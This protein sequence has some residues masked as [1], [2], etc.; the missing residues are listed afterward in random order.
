MK[1][2]I[3][4]QCV[5]RDEHGEDYPCPDRGVEISL[6]EDFH[7]YYDGPLKL[8]GSKA[9]FRFQESHLYVDVEYDVDGNPNAEE[10]AELVSYTQGQWSD[11]IGE[12]YEQFP[13]YVGPDGDEVYISMWHR[14]QVAQVSSIV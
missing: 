2:T 9:S 5:I 7:E 6:D 3:S 14:G 4:G 10:L 1:I 13:Q 11:G 8:N 12:G